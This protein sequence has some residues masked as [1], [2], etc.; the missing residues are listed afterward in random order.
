MVDLTFDSLELSTIDV[1]PEI[2]LDYPDLVENL[3]KLTSSAWH[4]R[5]IPNAE[6]VVGRQES[7]LEHSWL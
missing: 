7:S 1:V 2:D 5:Y 6:S 4:C 3:A